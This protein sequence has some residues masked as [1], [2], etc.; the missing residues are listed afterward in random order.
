MS[1]TRSAPS[2]MGQAGILLLA[3]A[4]LGLVAQLV[5]PTRI[6][7]REDWS[8]YVESKAL[9]AGLMLASL[10]DVQRILRDNT[11]LVLDARP[12][13]DYDRGHLPG[14]MSLPQ[15]QLDTY[16]PQILPLLSPAQP[17]LVYC[18]GEECDESLLLSVYLREQGYTNV[19]L[20]VGGYQAWQAAQ[21]AGEGSTP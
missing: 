3:A 5:S 13:V 2:P 20:F 16:Y 14:A 21:P 12:L 19:A 18:S 10:E 8:R 6:P 11:H 15:T 4:A 9:K 17:L 7:W 1:D